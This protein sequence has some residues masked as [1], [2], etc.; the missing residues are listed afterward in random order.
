MEPMLNLP[1]LLLK[2]LHWEYDAGAAFQP[3]RHPELPERLFPFLV[4][5]CPL[6]GNYFC[7]LS[8]GRRLK[9]APGEALLVPRGIPHTVAMPEPGILHFAH[10]QFNLFHGCDLL[11]FFQVP[12]HVGGE[13]A[14]QL[15]RLIETL[16]RN[17]AVPAAAA[18]WFSRAARGW[19]LAAELLLQLLAISPPQPQLEN[20][21]RE[22]S[23]LDGVLRYIQANLCRAIS[24]RELARLASLSETRFHYVFKNATGLAPMAYV[25]QIRMKRAQELLIRS[26]RPIGEIAPLAG[27]P[28]LFHFCKSFKKSF[29]ITPNAYRLACRRQ[30]NALGSRSASVF[31][32]EV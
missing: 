1:D 24:R 9:I 13:A 32:S 5:V 22:L 7:R 23:E 4:I 29:G 18:G 15:G 25:R 14:G 8:D 27:Y 12:F 30:L 11:Q 21:L 31:T 20:R 26:D 2:S 6:S 19:Q 10:I 3:V 28:D 17:L 16:H